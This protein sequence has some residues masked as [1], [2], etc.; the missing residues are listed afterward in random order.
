MRPGA[1]LVATL[2]LASAGVVWADAPFAPPA[3][4]TI[5][6]DPLGDAISFG[7]KVAERTSASVKASVAAGLS[8]TSCHLG[9]ACT[10]NAAPRVGL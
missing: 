1:A 8:C 9:G 4:D 7:Q 3:T 6:A 5:A 10:P 2:L